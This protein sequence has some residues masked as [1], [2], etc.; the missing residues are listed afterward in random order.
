[1]VIATME[2]VIVFLDSLAKSV[3]TNSVH[4]TVIC[5]VNVSME[6]AT[7]WLDGPVQIARLNSVPSASMV[8]AI[9]E[10]VFA[11]RD[12]LVQTVASASVLKSA[13]VT[14]LA[15]KDVA[16]VVLDTEVPH[17]R[18]KFAPTIAVT[19]DTAILFIESVDVLLDSLG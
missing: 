3:H 17:V 7:A 9:T 18:L 14:E 6:S 4:L 1:M 5:E 11:C 19:T 12:F 10:P 8:S 2:L 13:M 16:I 15:I